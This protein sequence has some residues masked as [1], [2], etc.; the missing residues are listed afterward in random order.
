MAKKGARATKGARRTL[1]QRAPGAQ[2]ASHRT[3]VEKLAR[4][5][6]MEAAGVPAVLE[7]LGFDIKQGVDNMWRVVRIQRSAA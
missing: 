7:E 1:S 6:D 4:I 2:A 5:A 3:L